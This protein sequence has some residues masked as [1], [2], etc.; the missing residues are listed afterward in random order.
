MG[1]E[2][3]EVDWWRWIGVVVLVEVG[4]VFVWVE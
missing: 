1:L 3:V 2:V 4:M